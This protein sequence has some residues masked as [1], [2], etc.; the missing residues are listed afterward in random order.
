[1]VAAK[2]PNNRGADTAPPSADA[3][4]WG[5]QEDFVNYTTGDVGEA[6]VAGVVTEG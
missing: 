4:S 6:L 1:M 3:S 2:S 5:I